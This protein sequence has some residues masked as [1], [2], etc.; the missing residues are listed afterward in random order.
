MLQLKKTTKIFSKGTIDEVTALDNISLDVHPQDYVTI[1]GS[2][3]AG[4]TTMLNVVAGVFPPERGG[5]VIVNGT[6]ITNLPEYKHATYVGRVY[7]NPNIGTAGKMTIEE[8]LA[9]AVLRGQPRGLKKA[10]NNQRREQFRAA[11]APLGLG[12]EDRLNTLAGTLSSGQRQGLALVMATISKP[13]LLLLDEHIANLDPR[14]AQTVLGLTDM[15]VGQEKM[16]TIMVTHNME[17]AM[18]YGNR[19]LMMHKGRV[20]VDIGQEKKQS[21]AINDLVTAFERA[22]GEQLA[23]ESILLSRPGG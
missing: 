8:N 15:I 13:A 19:L 5:S 18:R 7:Q 23:D 1:I 4:K 10:I 11:L 20:I 2:N 21:L 6:D 9:M 17:I 22:A 16:T 3:G 12:L 14:T